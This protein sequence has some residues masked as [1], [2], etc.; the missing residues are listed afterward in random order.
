MDSTGT[1][2]YNIRIY[3]YEDA[4]IDWT[5]L[6]AGATADELLMDS[7]MYTY[8]TQI[9]PRILSGD[10]DAYLEVIERIR[11]VDDLALYSGDF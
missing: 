4:P 11:P 7:T 3:L 5:E 1:I 10:I 8:C 6:I 2:Q 9:A